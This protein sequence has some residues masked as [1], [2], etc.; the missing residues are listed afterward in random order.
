MAA[1]Q[2]DSVWQ[3]GTLYDHGLGLQFSPWHNSLEEA[4]VPLGSTISAGVGM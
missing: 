3:G 2:Y 1:E 4:F